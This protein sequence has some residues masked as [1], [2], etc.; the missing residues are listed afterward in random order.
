MGFQEQLGALVREVWER[1]KRLR[2]QARVVGGRLMRTYLAEGDIYAMYGKNSTVAR[3][4]IAQLNGFFDDLDRIRAAHGTDVYVQTGEFF[5]FDPVRAILGGGDLQAARYWAAEAWDAF[6][7]FMAPNPCDVRRRVYV[8][9]KN[10]QSGLVILQTVVNALHT[11]RGQGVHEAKIAGPGAQRLDTVIVYCRD[12]HTAEAML[13]L[14]RGVDAG[15]FRR[16]VPAG[17]REVSNGVSVADQPSPLEV[18]ETFQSGRLQAIEAVSFGDFY[19][20]VIHMALGYPDPRLPDAHQPKEADS[21]QAL[22]ENVKAALTVCGVDPETPHEI[23]R[24]DA[25]LRGLLAS[26][27][28]ALARRR[29]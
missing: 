17:T 7:H 16:G 15:H 3:V 18:W 8:H 6:Y 4:D 22:E 9:A 29:R 5:P 10:T 12:D 27:K 13:A 26:A 21:L 2:R 19:A 1:E 20:K 23:A 14:L 11:P 28:A 25:Q 24:S